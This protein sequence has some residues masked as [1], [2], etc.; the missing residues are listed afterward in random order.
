[1]ATIVNIES[2]GTYKP[3]LAYGPYEYSGSLYVITCDWL[4]LKLMAYESNDDGA[5]WANVS[6]DG[7]EIYTYEGASDD[8]NNST[9]GAYFDGSLIHL[10]YFKAAAT[11]DAA[12]PTHCSFNPS[13]ATW[14]S[15]TSSSWSDTGR[16]ANP[17]FALRLCDWPG[18]GLLA[19]WTEYDTTDSA[20]RASIGRFSSGSWSDVSTVGTA[21]YW[22]SWTL[23]GLAPNTET[24]G[25]HVIINVSSSLNHLAIES[26][27]S[28]GSITFVDGSSGATHLNTKSWVHAGVEYLGVTWMESTRLR[29]ATTPSSSISF[30]TKTVY[31]RNASFE[32][33]FGQ[34]AQIV[35]LDESVYVFFWWTKFTSTAGANLYKSCL[36]YTETGASWSTAQQIAFKAS[37]DGSAFG[38]SA[39]PSGSDM[40]GC[41][42]PG[43]MREGPLHPV[44]N[45]YLD[46]ITEAIASCSSCCCYDFAY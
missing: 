35:P 4:T 17:S 34:S 5:T 2:Q 28:E 26:D 32:N 39:F 9:A 43:V 41:Y 19:G 13:T 3:F 38:F 33:A 12:Y 45:T 40:I 20:S 18:G 22:E 36:P 16:E 25:A 8:L 21:G 24:D 29:M 15:E 6:D 44:G 11:A 10:V 14:S 37:S 1:M 30:D 27:S 23:A 42:A 7:P 31:N 46:F